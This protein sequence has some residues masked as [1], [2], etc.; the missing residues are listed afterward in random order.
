MAFVLTGIMLAA[1][2]F[3]LLGMIK[4]GIG[5]AESSPPPSV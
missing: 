1:G 3:I 4:G 5:T 2:I